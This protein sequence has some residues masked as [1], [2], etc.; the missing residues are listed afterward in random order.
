MLNS[1]DARRVAEIQ[2]NENI[3]SWEDFFTNLFHNSVVVENL[4]QNLP[5]RYLLKVLLNFGKIAF[6]K[7]TGLY[8]IPLGLNKDI[9]GQPQLYDLKGFKGPS[10]RRRNDEIVVLRANDLEK[11][12]RPFIFQQSKLISEYDSAILQNLDAIRTQT[13]IEYQ[14]DGQ[15]LT[16]LNMAESRRI[17]AS[18]FVKNTQSMRGIALSASSTGAQFLVDKLQIAR[19]NVI[20]ET[21]GRLGI[22][23]ANT[24]K[25]EQMQATEVCAGNGANIDS[26][27]VLIDTF[28]HD[29]EIGG[30]DIRLKANTSLV[31]LMNID[32]ENG[33]FEN[34]GESQRQQM[35]I[36]KEDIK[37]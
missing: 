32:D 34:L 30:L 4:P 21:F 18:V 37:E 27:F 9:Y 23:S 13:I 11:P 35:N 16:A 10:L 2:K 7:I 1:R 22:A 17:G 8:L 29:S 33:D 36:T 25:R 24:S 6:D 31:D 14:E 15:A 5:K 20:D 28:N 3:D 19:Q 12:L 26:L